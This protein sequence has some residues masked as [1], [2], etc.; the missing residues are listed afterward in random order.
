MLCAGLCYKRVCG[1]WKL[2]EVQQLAAAVLLH[3]G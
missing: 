2:R 3:R 1:L